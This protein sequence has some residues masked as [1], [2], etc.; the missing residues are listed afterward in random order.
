MSIQLALARIFEIQDVKEEDRLAAWSEALKHTDQDQPAM[1][2]NYFHIRGLTSTVVFCKKPPLQGTV[3]SRVRN[4]DGKVRLA[5]CRKGQPRVHSNWH[6]TS[7]EAFERIRDNSISMRM[8]EPAISHTHFVEEGVKA[9]HQIYGLSRDGKEMSELFKLSIE[10]WQVYAKREQCA[11][12]LWGPHE[13]DNLMQL[14]APLWLMELY[15][16]V[17]FP[18]QRADIARFYILYMFGGL[19]ADLDTFPNLDRFPQVPL[20]MCK[21]L[22]QETKARRWNIEVVAGE[23]GHPAFLQIL[24]DMKVAIVDKGPMKYYTD[25][26]CRF[27]YDTTGPVRV[28]KTWEASGYQPHVTVFP[29]CRP[30]EDL[31]TII[32]LERTGRVRCHRYGMESYSVL[33]AP[34]LSCNTGNTRPPPPLAKPVPQPP[35]GRQRKKRLRFTIKKPELPDAEFTH[36]P[37]TAHVQQEETQPRKGIDEEMR[38]GYQPQQQRQRSVT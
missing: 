38:P 36:P 10:A 8:D 1:S 20:G 30:V 27:I 28:G 25:K 21:M 24:E 32:S 15:R 26:P 31:E 18:A 5:L 23:K 14:E 13:L 2:H 4:T 34:S 19:C 16:D 7:E 33:S 11:Y 17:R 29:M 35:P 37:S 3:Q 22:A 9:I 12:T 6:G